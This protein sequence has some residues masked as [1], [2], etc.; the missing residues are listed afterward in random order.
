M[1]IKERAGHNQKPAFPRALGGGNRAGGWARCPPGT[2]L[3]EA[4]RGCPS[5]WPVTRKGTPAPRIQAFAP[6]LPSPGRPRGAREWGVERGPCRPPLT[7]RTPARPLRPGPARTHASPCGALGDREAPPQ[8]GWGLGLHS[9]RPGRFLQAS[10]CPS[11]GDRR[12]LGPETP[13]HGFWLVCFLQLRGPRKCTPKASGS[14]ARR[15]KAPPRPSPRCTVPRTGQL[16]GKRWERQAGGQGSRCG[17][18]AVLPGRTP[19]PQRGIRPGPGTVRLF[20]RWMSSEPPC[21]HAPSV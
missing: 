14:H 20:F 2:P 1:A 13:H 5:P 18:D 7:C 3:R 12:V 19:Q 15:M 16:P 8:G 6:R 11:L 10:G 4:A 17:Q 21:P 9:W